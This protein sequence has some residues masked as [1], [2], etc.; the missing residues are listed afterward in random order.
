[1][2][3]TALFLFVCGIGAFVFAAYLM[4]ADRSTSSV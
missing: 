2:E 3:K 4:N 1:M